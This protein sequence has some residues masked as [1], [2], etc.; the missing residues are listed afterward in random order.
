MFKTRDFLPVVITAV[1]GFAMAIAGLAASHTCAGNLTCWIIYPFKILF[2]QYVAQPNDHIL[3]TLAQLFAKAIFL[4]GV[5][6][7]GVRVLLSAVRHDFRI[8]RARRM[9]NHTVVCGLGETGMQIVHNIRPASDLVVVDRADDT[10]NA[11][12]CDRLGIPLIKGDAT[13][14]DVL[15]YAG[16]LHAQTI[17]VCTGDDASNIDVALRIKD[18]ANGHRRPGSSALLVLAEMRHQWLFSRLIN[19]DR[20]ALGSIDVNLRLF[21]TY[22]NAAR[23]FI[24]SIRLPP[25]PEISAG[26]FVIAGFGAMG[27]QILLHLIR[28]A[29]TVVGSK[30]K[31]VV[32]DR[33]TE[34]HKL[35]FFQS[36]PAVTEFADVSF[37]EA[38][39]SLDS[40]EVW[41][42]VDKIVN[43]LPLFGIAICFNDD[44]TSLYAGLS[45]RRLLDDRSRTH[46][47]MYLRL[48]RHRHLGE[49]A[50]A[51]ERMPGP[52]HR[53]QSF[54][55]LEELLSPEILI[56]GKLDNLAEA[57]HTHYR[58]LRQ[59]VGRLSPANKPWEML[60]ET[61][62]MSNRR[63]ADNVSILLAQAGL[64]LAASSNPVPLELKP[65]EIELLAQLE[66][67]RWVIERRLV[68]VKYGEVRTEYPP[69]HELLVDWEHL[70]ETEREINRADFRMLSKI[71]AD[72]NFEIRRERKILAIGATLGAAVAKLESAIAIEG[73]EYLVIADIDES[74]GRKAAALAL[75]LPKSELWLVSSD[76]PHQFR[77]L[78][79]LG[80]IRDGATGWVTRQQFQAL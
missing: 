15:T 72:I 54:G 19:H 25:G 76:Y 21:N 55:G 46:V 45:M 51:M 53:L 47:P 8:A 10:T 12:I 35:Q 38:N 13:N 3:L 29:P 77:E 20:Q 7:S 37:V 59:T 26:A 33:G 74:E 68:G 66:H 28:A 6:L 48:E 69:Q 18:L 63:R 57:F 61:F 50:A 80:A 70:P 11:T 5:F 22:E 32:L 73:R 2:G 4:V 34:Q 44:Q 62:K 42:T 75:K 49:F 60:A 27:Q 1:V 58:D 56:Q 36:Y 79:Q 31:I 52:R 41:S 23:L 14:T 64:R 65:E 17:V 30:T 9:K 40:Q 71:L 24:R 67:R 16:T 78:Q 39:I 43:D